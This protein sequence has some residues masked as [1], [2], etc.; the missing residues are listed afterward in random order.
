MRKKIQK[1]INEYAE[2]FDT[3]QVKIENNDVAI[4]ILQEIGK[5]RRASTIAEPAQNALASEK[6]KA[7]MRDLGIDFNESI[8][9]KEA[10]DLIEQ[11][12]K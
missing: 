8:T 2:L 1:S 7:Y 4:A 5:D 9:R 11:N 10:S 6:Q 3:I 12:Q